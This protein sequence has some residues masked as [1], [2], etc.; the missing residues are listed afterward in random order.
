MRFA[1]VRLA[2]ESTHRTCNA[3]ISALV[4]VLHHNWKRWLRCGHTVLCTTQAITLHSRHSFRGG[5]L[6]Q[7]T[8]Q[9]LPDQVLRP[10]EPSGFDALKVHY[11][12]DERV[13]VSPQL[14]A[15]P[16]HLSHHVVARAQ[17]VR[18]LHNRGIVPV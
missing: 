5:A 13:D 11:M 17:W 14:V 16:D 2:V 6:R 15:D 18:Y 9:L 3:H 4:P 7:G 10:I 8:I 12:P 1:E